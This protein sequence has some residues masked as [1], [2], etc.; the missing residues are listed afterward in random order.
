MHFD[1]LGEE[2]DRKAQVLN[3]K[4]AR[5]F[6]SETCHA[7][8]CEYANPRGHFRFCFPIVTEKEERKTRC[9]S[10]LCRVCLS[11]CSIQPDGRR[12][13]GTSPHTSAQPALIKFTKMVH[14]SI[15]T[16]SRSFGG[17]WPR[18]CIG[19]VPATTSTSMR[20]TPGCNL[21]SKSG[22]PFSRG[23]CCC[24]CFSGE[25]SGFDCCCVGGW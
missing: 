6:L 21:A 15:S 10:F 22:W 7:L 11:I 16:A 19:A 14:F 24:C 3:N 9:P 23:C 1:K 5:H 12:V 18:T 13:P 4:T 2:D 25:P 17:G 8:T 20:L